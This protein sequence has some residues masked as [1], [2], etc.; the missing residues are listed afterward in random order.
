MRNRNTRMNDVESL[1]EAYA[2][3]NKELIGWDR[4][5][6]RT[7]KEELN[8]YLFNIGCEM[9]YGTKREIIK[10]LAYKTCGLEVEV[11]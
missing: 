1:I 2:V 3:G 4:V 8:D 6:K 11:A 10:Q 7:T 5:I 9:V